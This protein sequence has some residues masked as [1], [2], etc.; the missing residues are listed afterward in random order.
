MTP[1]FGLSFIKECLHPSHAAYNRFKIDP[2]LI[3][4]ARLE[5][6]AWKLEASRSGTP[7]SEP[8]YDTAEIPG[9]VPPTSAPTAIMDM[10]PKREKPAFKLGSPFSPE[11]EQSYAYSRINHA[12]VKDDSVS[13]KSSH[14]VAPTSRTPGEFILSWT[15]INRT[16]PAPPTNTPVEYTSHALQLLTQPHTD[17]GAQQ[18]SWRGLDGHRSTSPASASKKTANISARQSKGYKRAA[19][20]SDDEYEDADSTCSSSASSLAGDT[21]NVVT[22]PPPAP[23]R[24]PTKRLRR[25]HSGRETTAKSSNGDMSTAHKTNKTNKSTKL[26]SQEARAALLLVEI[27]KGHGSVDLARKPTGNEQYY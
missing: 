22:S 23:L 6:Q 21:S 15:S 8:F 19:E 11:L 16:P 14:A 1:I 25:T 5:A 27:S 24:R 3:R 13:P 26:T 18:P 17:L 12:D 9:S 20:D 10:R 4:Q 7:A 2:Q